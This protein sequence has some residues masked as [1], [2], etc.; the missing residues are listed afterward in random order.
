MADFDPKKRDEELDRFWEIDELIPKKKMPRY[1]ADVEAV[2]ITIA[3][4]ENPPQ[5]RS[6]SAPKPHF[7]PP[8]TA[9][10]QTRRPAPLLE[11]VPKNAL[12]RA[13]R[14]YPWNSTHAYYEDFFRN[15]TRLAAVSGIACERVP[16]FSS[17]SIQML[18]PWASI[19]VFEI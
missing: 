7:I 9:D 13:V 3:P 14:I 18:S 19:I 4:P 2:E 17:G 10:E 15:A 1:P 16:F 12:I 5:K 6:A 8:H 11:Y